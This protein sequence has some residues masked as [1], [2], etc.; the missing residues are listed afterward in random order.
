MSW[1]R[2]WKMSAVVP[3]GQ[4]EGS[5]NFDATPMQVC[6]VPELGYLREDFPTVKRLFQVA[7]AEESSRQAYIPVYDKEI[8]G[9]C[10]YCL[11]EGCSCRHDCGPCC[12]WFCCP[13]FGTDPQIS[14]GTP[15][16]GAE[17][18]LKRI[19]ELVF[20]HQVC[21]QN[22]M[23][24][25][26]AQRYRKFGVRTS[27]K[28]EV[29]LQVAHCVPVE[30][31]KSLHEDVEA[32]MHAVEVN[33]GCWSKEYDAHSMEV[34]ANEIVQKHG[35]AFKAVGV[36]LTSTGLN[37]WRYPSQVERF[38]PK[39]G[40]CSK[41]S[42][43]GLTDYYEHERHPLH[44][45][46]SLV[47]TATSNDPNVTTGPWVIF[48][49]SDRFM[50]P[51]TQSPNHQ[52]QLSYHRKTL[53]QF[54]G[55]HSEVAKQMCRP[56]RGHEQAMVQQ[57]SPGVEGLGFCGKCGKAKNGDNFCAGCGDNFCAPP[58]FLE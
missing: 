37:P 30:M 2:S 12:P 24:V 15:I 50:K 21:D 1:G 35:E 23:H 29:P 47:L 53:D 6:S 52:E 7:S 31:W 46:I 32:R 25:D 49:D 42:Q 27:T 19:A 26:L 28:Q 22:L 57:V 11:C 54:P 14:V 38:L 5:R 58:G 33:T 3:T 34:H 40:C 20:F 18:L 10:A 13:C 16:N 36:E 4:G 9:S 48:S 17:E 51:P 43:G 56:P 45:T 8:P 39:R 55:D 44:D 41:S